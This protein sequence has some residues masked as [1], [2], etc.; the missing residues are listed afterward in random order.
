MFLVMTIVNEMSHFGLTSLFEIKSKNE[1]LG[2]ITRHVCVHVQFMCYV[3]LFVA[4]L[5]NSL[6]DHNFTMNYSI[7]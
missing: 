7:G 3:L 1:G 4:S 2:H 5:A 6:I